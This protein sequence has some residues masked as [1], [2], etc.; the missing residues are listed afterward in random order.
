MREK[1]RE[2]EE[3]RESRIVIGTW[4]EMVEQVEG[5]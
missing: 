4:T 3:K 1:D 2:E 5:A